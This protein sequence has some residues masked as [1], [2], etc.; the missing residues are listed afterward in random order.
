M[1]SLRFCLPLA[2]VLLVSVPVAAQKPDLTTLE[3]TFKR[4]AGTARGRVG[5]ALIHLESGAT[6]HL[7]GDERFPMASVVKL[8][9]AIEVLKQV[10]ERTIT[11]DRAVW[12]AASDIRPCCTIERRH[13][14]GGVSRT[15][16]RAA[17][18]GD[19]RKRQH[20]C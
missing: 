12:L 14:Q 5:V 2:L 1:T 11:L 3:T 17:R 18:V 13:P 15:G 20:S 10:A 7:R 16:T 9:I 19:C 8:P 4:I 6:L